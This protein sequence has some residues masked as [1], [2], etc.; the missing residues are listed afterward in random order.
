[1]AMLNNKRVT[2]K[3]ELI[4]DKI[5]VSQW[6]NNWAVKDVFFSNPPWSYIFWIGLKENLQEAI[7]F[8][9]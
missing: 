1:M 4:G 9:I 2:N 3:L 7:V 8:T 5:T 6:G